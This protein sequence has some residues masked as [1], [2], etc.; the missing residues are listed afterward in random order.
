MTLGN[1]LVLDNCL[2]I[3]TYIPGMAGDF[4][5]VCLFL[6]N[7]SP[8]PFI[9]LKKRLTLKEKIKLRWAE[10]RKD[11]RRVSVLCVSWVLLLRC[12]Y[13]SFKVK[14]SPVDEKFSF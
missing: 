5:F 11:W 10:S 14:D 7:W 4:L 8:L 12:I 13:N 9:I 3:D 1:L 2:M 6:Y